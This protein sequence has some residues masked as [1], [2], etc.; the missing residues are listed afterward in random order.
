MKAFRKASTLDESVGT[1]GT[2]WNDGSR[3]ADAGSVG[4]AEGAGSPLPDLA[5]GT[6]LLVDVGSRGL[7][8]CD[9]GD[10]VD[11]NEALVSMTLWNGCLFVSGLTQHAM[12]GHAHERRCTFRLFLES[13]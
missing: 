7:S 5:T 3:K 12:V 13:F 1:V 8:L 9:A 6:D 2:Y 4:S 11:G 10:S